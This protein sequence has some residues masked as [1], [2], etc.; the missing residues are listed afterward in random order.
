MVLLLLYILF[1][2]LW[3]N[4]TMKDVSI[5]KLKMHFYNVSK[6][7][8]RTFQVNCDGN[9]RRLMCLSTVGKGI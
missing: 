8:D 2:K 3:F 6:S 1:F 5:E 9:K 7:K 4:E